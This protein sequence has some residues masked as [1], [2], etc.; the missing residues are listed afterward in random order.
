MVYIL[1]FGVTTTKLQ[2]CKKFNV[3]TRILLLLLATQDK[4]MFEL[5][6][7]MLKKNPLSLDGE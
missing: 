1:R 5:V 7:F 2:I 3:S 4:Q 6:L